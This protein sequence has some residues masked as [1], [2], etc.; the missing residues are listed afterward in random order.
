M[1][2]KRKA[3]KQAS[4]E[5]AAAMRK[6]Y[7]ECARV[8]AL[9]LLLNTLTAILTG[10][11]SV[12]AANV[13]GEF[14]DAVFGQNLSLGLRNIF[15]LAGCILI[16]AFV[17]PM[18]GML[19]DFF[20]LKSAL[21]HD[22]LVFGRY[23][24]KEPE[25]ARAMNNGEVKYQLEDAPNTLRIQWV[26]LLSKALSVPFILVYLLSQSGRISWIL[27]GIMILLVALRLLIPMIFQKKLAAYDKSEKAY[28]AKRREYE[29]DA[30]SKP[31]LIKLWGIQTNIL[32]RIDC[33][34]QTFF[35]ES[36]V[37]QITC[38]ICA[39]QMLEFL[40]SMTP[41]LL[42]LAGAL[43][44]AGGQVTPGGLAAMYAF[45]PVVQTV[46]N[47][48]VTIIRDY[49]LICNAAERVCEFYRDPEN[50]DGLR[51]GHFTGIEARKVSFSYMDRT[52]FRN[53]NFSVS[54]GDKIA[55]L[56]GNGRGKST[57]IKIL[58]QLLKSYTGELQIGRLETEKQ[59]LNKS[60]AEKGE[61]SSLRSDAME[62]RA[63]DI[64]MV[65]VLNWRGLIACAPQKPFLFSGTVRENIMLG[66]PDASREEADRLLD[67][68]GI[69]S[70]AE[71]QISMNSG[72]SGG[73]MQ[74][75]SLIRALLRQYEFLI[76]DEPSNH[77]DQKSVIVLKEVINATDKTVLLIT[78][79][80]NLLDV[81]NAQIWV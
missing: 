48:F 7:Q 25:K 26:V 52:V 32:N 67:A 59:A 18:L 46:F 81:V 31:Y 20:M 73:E 63:Y 9:P 80:E 40:N 15:V 29:T 19:S 58:C 22:N 45:L 47:D 1:N 69:A 57:L 14:T 28:Y 51:I 55:I 79:D 8:T 64:K 56:G 35:S 5:K 49:P 60:K 12:T 72:L 37:H 21:R 78:H 34:Y 66:N 17:G 71:K 30:A 75:V 42:L 24:D 13:L 36:G 10:T 61:T 43:M 33:L 41:L 53:L 4:N 23:L 16:L 2:K 74:K 27:T 38:R 65:N 76:L 11:I 3:G 44:V 70:L 39:E 77:L 50:T 62:A 68:F 54:V 6:V